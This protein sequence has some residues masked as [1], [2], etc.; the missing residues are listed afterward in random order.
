MRVTRLLS[1][2][3]AMLVLLAVPSVASASS[4]TFWR[5]SAPNQLWVDPGAGTAGL[6]VLSVPNIGCNAVDANGFC[7]GGIYPS[8]PGAHW[9]WKTAETVEAQN[10]S[11][12]G[13]VIFFA[14]STCPEGRTRWRRGSRSLPTTGMTCS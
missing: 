2:A 5:V 11:D 7:T 10:T 3:G 8:L 9:I 4:H 6:S 13:P 14:A 12:Y 1:L